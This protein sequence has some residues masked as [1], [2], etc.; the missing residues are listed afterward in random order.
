MT[1]HLIDIL[2]IA[3]CLGVGYWIVSSIMGKGVDSKDGDARQARRPAPL[4]APPATKDEA[5]APRVPLPAPPPPTTSRPRGGSS[6]PWHVV[7]DIPRDASARDIEAARRRRMAAAESAGDS[8]EMER[9][10]RAAEEASKQ[11]R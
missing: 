5:P 1:M 2:I 9:I 10:R 7:L 6:Q 4:S 11:A 8:F 3:G